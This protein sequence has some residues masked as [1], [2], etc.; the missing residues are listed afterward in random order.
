[1]K[2]NFVKDKVVLVT[3][4]GGGSGREFA[5]AL[6]REVSLRVEF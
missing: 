3:G 6:A 2:H 5:I 4:A 1:M